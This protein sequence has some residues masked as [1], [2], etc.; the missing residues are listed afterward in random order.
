M[1]GFTN[2][3]NNT[4]F[5]HCN[6]EIQGD[7][8][9]VNDI[10]Y[11]TLVVLICVFGVLAYLTGILSISR[12]TKPLIESRHDFTGISF[13]L[14][15][16]SILVFIM[17]FKLITLQNMDDKIYVKAHLF[18]ALSMTV[19]GILAINCSS[20]INGNYTTKKK[21]LSIIALHGCCMTIAMTNYVIYFILFFLAIVYI[22]GFNDFTCGI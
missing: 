22:S 17:M 12:F 15:V 14:M 3:T 8:V 10:I 1:D 21:I 19:L 9:I 16:S 2:F 6:D 13:I 5:T 4:N 20:N 7:I 11:I 18:T